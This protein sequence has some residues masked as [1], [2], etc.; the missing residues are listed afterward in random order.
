MECAAR[1]SMFKMMISSSSALTAKYAGCHYNNII[2]IM[3][4]TSFWT[5]HSVTM[6]PSPLWPVAFGVVSSSRREEK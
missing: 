6:T 1:W 5:I 3:Q 4:V 2:P